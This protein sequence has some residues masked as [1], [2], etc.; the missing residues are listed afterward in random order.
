MT[1]HSIINIYKWQL[2]LF[3][4]VWPWLWEITLNIKDW[5][6]TYTVFL[7]MHKI[8]IFFP[9]TAF[10]FHTL[11]SFLGC[12]STFEPTLSTVASCYLLQLD[13]WVWQV[14][15]GEGGS[16]WVGRKG[17]VLAMAASPTSCSSCL[18]LPLGPTS[19][20]PDIRSSPAPPAPWSLG[21]CGPCSCSFL[22]SHRC[23]RHH[24]EQ[25]K[26]ISNSVTTKRQM[27]KNSHE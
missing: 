7:T 8:T 21:P 16:G 18:P 2:Y 23:R 27:W 6:W 12:V 22:W 17:T 19:L 26:S 14:K 25:P 10:H 13:G 3:C 24:L 20:A 15:P 5:A 4:W 1:Y 11:Y 9:N